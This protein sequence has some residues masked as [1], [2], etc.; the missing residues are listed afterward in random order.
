MSGRTCRPSFKEP[1]FKGLWVSEEVLGTAKMNPSLSSHSNSNVDDNTLYSVA[2]DLIPALAID[3][4]AGSC[5]RYHKQESWG[6]KYFLERRK[7]QN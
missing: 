1:T 5:G 6:E 2:K 4:L 3:V 7:L